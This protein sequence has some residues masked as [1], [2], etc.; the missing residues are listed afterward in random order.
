ML[1]WNK[2]P[3][4]FDLKTKLVILGLFFAHENQLC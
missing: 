1:D 4:V 2:I 3:K